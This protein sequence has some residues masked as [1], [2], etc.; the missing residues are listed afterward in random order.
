MEMIQLS[1]IN[2]IYR[3]E[4]V[5]ALEDKAECPVAERSQFLI[6][7]VFHASTIDFDTSTGRA[8]QQTHNV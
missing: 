1:S 2:K 8:V 5:E 4:E 7:Y 3:T 6:A